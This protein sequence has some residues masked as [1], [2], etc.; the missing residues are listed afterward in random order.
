MSGDDA[1]R[2]RIL[3]ELDSSMVVV[4]GAGTGKTT[5]L[6]DRIVQLVRTGR[7]RVKDIAAI[8]FTEA[9]AE[10][11]RQRVRE[12]LESAATAVADPHLR[13]AANEVDEAAI[14][15]L[16]SFAQRMLRE[17]C[18]A[19]GLPSGFEVLD[20]TAD[21]SDF[22]ERWRRFADELFE[23]PTMAPV[24]V[25]GFVTGLRHTG[26]RAIANAL[27]R[28]WGLLDDV[29]EDG[30]LIASTHS[31]SAHIDANAV[32]ENLDKALALENLCT[33]EEDLLLGHLHTKVSEARSILMD[34]GDDEEAILYELQHM[35]P[36]KCRLGQHGNWSGRISEVRQACDAAEEA[37]LSILSQVHVSVLRAV[38][39]RLA[40]FVLTSAEERRSEGTLNYDDLLVQAR[41]LLRQGGEP[42]EA[43]RRRYRFILIDEF[44]DTD[45]IQVELAG[46]LTTAVPDTADLH[47][48]RP[49]ALFVVGDPKQS[50]Y[51]FRRADM[52]LFDEVA[53]EIARPAVLETNFRSVPGIIEFVNSTFLELFG[54]DPVEGQA[55]YSPLVASR[56][57]LDAQRRSSAASEGLA[58]RTIFRSGGR[59]T[60]IGGG[61]ATGRGR[62]RSL[63]PGPGQLELFRNEDADEET[64]QRRAWAEAKHAVR[65]DHASVPA[66]SEAPVIVTGDRLEGSVAD[67][68][69]CSTRD[70]A[71]AVREVVQG[72]FL[73]SED[74][75]TPTRHARYRDVAVL[76]PTRTTVPY[77]EE[78]FEDAKV[79]YR[80]EGASMLWSSAEVRDVLSLLS[81]AD[82]PADEI[83]VVSALRSPGL[84]CG[85]DDL[86]TWQQNEGRFDP[87]HAPPQDLE[88]SPVARGM[89]V[90]AEIHRLRPWSE[91]SV[92]VGRAYEMLRCFELAFAHPRPRDH[93]QR[94][95]WLHD[96]ARRFDEDS[97]GTLRAFLWWAKLQ[98]D[99]YDDTGIGPPD[100][101]DDAVRV[102]TVHGSKGLEFPVVM[103]CGLERQDGDGR[104]PPT[105]LWNEDGTLEVRAG[106]EFWTEGYEEAD[107]RDQHL[108]ALERLRL[109]YVAM[110]R[111]RDHLLLFVHHRGQNGSGDTSLASVLFDICNAR[112]SLWRSL[113][114]PGLGA[115]TAEV[116]RFALEVDEAS[117][118]SDLSADIEE[119][120]RF[121]DEWEQRRSRLLEEMRRRPVISATAL[122]EQ[123]GAEQPPP[124]QWNRTSR[125]RGRALEMGL[126]LHEVL[127]AVDLSSGLDASGRSVEEIAAVRAKSRRIEKD[128]GKIAA[129][130]SNALATETLRR[131]A[132]RRHWSE[133]YVAAPVID[134]ES[135]KG[136]AQ[137]VS[138]VLEGF[139]DLVFEDDDGLV[140]VDYKTDEVGD[141]R[142][143]EAALSRHS[144]QVAAY[145]AALE[146]ST[147][148]RV[149]RCV[150]LFVATSPA[151]EHVIE[152]DELSSLRA[153]ALGI[154]EAA[155]A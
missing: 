107:E 117:D 100:P 65:V 137:G 136:S 7:S 55:A 154:A 80:L 129:F 91:V 126:A 1:V 20:E 94:L 27:H 46:R 76:V 24:L 10:E 112:K 17:H 60:M 47:E 89:E 102:M 71:R 74:G 40:A 141:G 148:R 115:A 52:E 41:R 127:A 104:P 140:V 42:L 62:G 88:D 22:D 32:I 85:D 50:I 19:S 133:I 81:A 21:A 72:G 111:A 82:D 6:V 90:I 28:Q 56:P 48:T 151:L 12:A 150:V 135:P 108:D 18:A 68:R 92:L 118:L 63:Y 43:L 97:G 78:A 14:S 49:G 30:T 26:L 120:R 101:D 38:V 121:V 73:V 130:A 99:G 132:T 36:L 122:T 138:G 103:L 77:L 44:Q 11:L 155:L 75:D 13:A 54:Y 83:S 145:A 149:S 57:P 114:E 144:I 147:A 35:P 16:H 58:G 96:Q 84:A 9:A 128:E 105:V 116:G 106:P 119:W 33:H 139:I 98:A 131:A 64:T 39:P 23:D 124:E 69:R 110:T 53:R 3:E 5:V 113:P 59:H 61:R 142:D 2:S 51:R 29:G 134:S 93:W 37:R 4:A 70:V 79:P 95:R 87:L 153:R 86:L 15:T 152:S 143:L 31:T 125:D 45:P 123:S 8:T 66:L 34:A 146:R 109:L 25:R 67:I